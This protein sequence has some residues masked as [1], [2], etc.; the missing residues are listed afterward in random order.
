MNFTALMLMH[1]RSKNIRKL[2]LNTAMTKFCRRQD[3]VLPVEK[4]VPHPVVFVL[5]EL[6]E[7][8]KRQSHRSIILPPISY[9]R[10]SRHSSRTCSSFHC[11]SSARRIPNI[12]A[13]R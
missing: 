11:A 4:L 8:L 5:F 13:R 2:L 10:W 12:T 9:N 1:V 3:D 7:G 6:V